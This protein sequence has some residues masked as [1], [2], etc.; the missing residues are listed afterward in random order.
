MR[1]KIIH[2]SA[3]S[4]AVFADT[5][6]A[7]IWLFV[8]LY[9]GYQWLVAGW[10]KFSN[11]AWVGDRAGTALREFLDGSLQKTSG[12]HPDVS[13]WY[14]TFIQHIVLSHLT[15]FSYMVTYGEL[16]VG[17]ALVLGIFTGIA[18]CGGIV[19]NVNYL[20]AGTISTNPILLLLQFLLILA[21]RTA[22][23]IGIDRCIHPPVHA[24]WKE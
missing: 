18:A 4:R 2:E 24:S 6:L 7:W 16:G 11:Q 22:G 13:A 20:L 5:R 1:S 10:E 14:A 9:V 3:L 21:W 15:L 12:L 8:R 19:M 17:I 23:W